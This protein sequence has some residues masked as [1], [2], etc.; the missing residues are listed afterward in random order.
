MRYLFFALMFI[1]LGAVIPEKP[2]KPLTMTQ[3]I[4]KDFNLVITVNNDHVAHNNPQASSVQV[5]QKPEPESSPI[6]KKLQE[7]KS[8]LHVSERMKDILEKR[9]FFYDYKWHLLGLTVAGSYAFLLYIIYAGNSYLSNNELWSSWRQDLPLDQLLA[10]PQEQF[11]QELIR[12]IQRRYTDP[13]SVI[14]LVKPLSE[15][16]ITTNDEEEQLRWYQS[17]FG[18]LSYLQLIKIV[19]LSK[20]RFTKINERLQR[21]AYYKNIFQSWAADYQ[22]N[23]RLR[24]QPYEIFDNE[25]IAEFAEYVH[26]LMSNQLDD[27]WARKQ[28]ALIPCA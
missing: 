5:I 28:N 7:I 26:T 11:S 15:F 17:T 16:I 21:L 20:Q 8:E 27:H 3:K 23:H 24:A 10:I 6:L 2:R 12:E 14:D 18:W 4:D 9:S 13:R 25:N 22:L 19:P 1:S